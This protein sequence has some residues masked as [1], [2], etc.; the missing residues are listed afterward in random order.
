M[1]FHG[2]FIGIDRYDSPR[3]N[4]LT[5]ARQ[6]ATALH[7]LFTDTLGGDTTLLVDETATLEA[8]ESQFSR[9]SQCQE[10]DVVVIAFSGHGSETHEVVLYDTDPSDLSSTGLPLELL[11]RWFASIPARR[12]VCILDCCF[13]GGM[14]AKVLKVDAASRNLQSVESALEEMKGEGRLILTA[15]SATEEAWENGRLRHGL[16]TYYLLEALQGAE[17]VRQGGKVAVLRLLEFV[18]QRVTA[19]AAALGKPQHPTMRGQLDGELTWP[20]FHPGQRYAAAFP[21]HGRLNASADIGSLAA[22]GFPEAFLGAWSGAIPSLNQL[23]VD[24]INEYGVLDGQHLVVSAP[25]SSGKTMIGE[26]AAL[27]GALER[28]R[29]LFLLPLKAL[30]NDKHQQFVRTYG[31][32]GIRT[33]RATGEIMDPAL[34]RG[35]YDICLLT[36]EKFGNL[37]LAYPHLLDQVGC[38]VVDEVQ[39]IADSSRGVNLEFVLTLLRMRRRSGVEPQLIALSAVI[40]D[41]NGLERWLDS[42]LLRRTDR[43]VPLDEGL[44][45]ADGSFRYIEPDSGVERIDQGHVRRIYGKGSSQD[46]VIPLVRRLVGEGKQ[47]I[48]FRERK[49]EAVGCAKYLARELGLPAADA[50]LQGLPTGDPSRSSEDLRLALRSGI[51]FHTADLSRDERLVIEQEFRAPNSPVRVIAATTTLAMGV[52][53]PAEAVVI[54]GLEHPGSGP[55]S[56]AE[57]KNICGRAGRLGFSEHGHSYLLALSPREEYEYWTRYVRG[58]PENIESRFLVEGTDPRSLIVRVLAAAQRSAAR[59]LTDENIVEFLEG[60]FGAFQLVQRNDRWSWDRGQLLESLGDLERHRLV[61]RASEGGYRL[62]ELGRL[63]GQGGVEVESITRLVE[64]LA[65]LPVA[66][67]NDPTLIT[68]TQLTVELDAVL[69]PINKASTQKEPQAWPNELAA[70]GVAPEVLRA[71]HHSVSERHVPTLR[72]KKAVACLLWIT[73]WP[74][75]RIEE[76]LTRFSRPEPIAGPIRSITE[77]TYDLLGTV[78]S[79]AMILHPDLNLADRY[80]RLLTRLEAGVTAAAAAIASKADG[81]LGRGDYQRLLSA[82][83]CSAEAIEQC[84]DGDLLACLDGSP[85]KLAALRKAA[86]R[87]GDAGEVPLL[88]YPIIP[89]YVG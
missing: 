40:G 86:K 1:S 51:A 19:G 75:S 22:F 65:P 6:D 10:E 88:A 54:V 33:V 23:Q 46:W 59:P 47:V 21:E 25:T 74:M 84:A 48:V 30:V 37:A 68:A 67:I 36:Y 3:I 27:Q 4:W 62:T 81:A 14:G 45:L 49:G 15:S 38:I 5:C 80:E 20:I 2:L 71:L 42:R 35:Q 72:A 69:F 58:T 18:V 60:S 66:S 44:L 28:K 83:L 55:Y 56:I 34:L 50:A 11:A 43:P 87:C 26:L 32:L 61:E 31:D 64:V 41:T 9:L 89:P 73:D 12:L 52:N 53:T 57:Y 79:V 77:R 78:A 70:Q 7:A 24:A 17:E 39:M 82:G 16:L 63:C 85:A 76:T 29:T 13:S 8:V